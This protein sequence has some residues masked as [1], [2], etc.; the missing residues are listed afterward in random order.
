MSAIEAM[1]RL[2]AGVLTGVWRHTSRWYHTETATLIT[3]EQYRA[4]TAD[5]RKQYR[6]E[7][8]VATSETAKAGDSLVVTKSRTGE[9]AVM[10]LTQLVGYRAENGKREALWYASAVNPHTGEPLE[11]TT[12]TAT[13][14]LV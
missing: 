4:L 8:A 5:E 10:V 11:T 7:Y 13:T 2:L 14:T 12:S 3:S 9:L 6:R 1:V